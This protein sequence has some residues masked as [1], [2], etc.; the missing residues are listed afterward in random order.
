MPCAP[1]PYQLNTPSLRPPLIA[2]KP[3]WPK[4][5]A[6]LFPGGPQSAPENPACPL[7]PFPHNPSQLLAA[8]WQSAV[9][10]ERQRPA[11]RPTATAKHSRQKDC[12]VVTRRPCFLLRSSTPFVLASFGGF[13][14]PLGLLEGLP[15]RSP[16]SG[17]RPPGRA[18]RAAPRPRDPP[19]PCPLPSGACA[20]GSGA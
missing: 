3:L 9:Y 4:K 1:P 13:L 17:A 14:S 11:M 19:R 10:S 2:I 6:R 16:L 5:Y 18:P 20:G 15:L 7:A 8:S 12:A